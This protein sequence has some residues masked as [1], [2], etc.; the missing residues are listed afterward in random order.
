ALKIDGHAPN[1]LNL[2]SRKYT[3]YRTLNI[4]TWEGSN[5]ENRHA[6]RLADYL[7]AQ[8]RRLEEKFGIIPASSLRQAGW[9]F[10]DNELV[11][12]GE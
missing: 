3:L 12:E 2:L 10:R 8:G 11:G 9:K 4:T 6:Q 1:K 5:I 7:L